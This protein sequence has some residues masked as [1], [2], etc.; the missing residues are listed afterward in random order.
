MNHPTSLNFHNSATLVHLCNAASLN[1]VQH[2]DKAEI[3]LSSMIYACDLLAELPINVQAIYLKK[4]DVP[5][6]YETLTELRDTLN[7]LREIINSINAQ[8][9]TD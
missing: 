9:N 3:E 1:L 2:L 6:D 8:L 5:F 7:S 4:L